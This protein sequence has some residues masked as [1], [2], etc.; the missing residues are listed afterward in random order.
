MPVLPHC[1]NGP[2]EKHTEQVLLREFENITSESPLQ[3]TLSF[4]AGLCP[5]PAQKSMLH[6][7]VCRNWVSNASLAVD[8]LDKLLRLF[9]VI[10]FSPICLLPYLQ[11]H[12]QSCVSSLI[13]SQPSPTSLVREVSL[14][15]GTFFQI[16]LK[17]FWP[18]D[19]HLPSPPQAELSPHSPTVAVAWDGSKSHQ[20]NLKRLLK[21][22]SLIQT[23]EWTQ[24]LT[25]K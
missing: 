1:V 3:F 5:G 6:F 18:S 7:S 9:I 2:R 11:L 21:P 20:I 14:Q 13:H 8:R 19:V 12:W 23:C 10:P 17:R 16:Q 15:A 25:I 4:C 24:K 22:L